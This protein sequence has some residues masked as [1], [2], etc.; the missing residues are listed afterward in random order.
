MSSRS[1]N[2]SSMRPKM[3]VSV[4][5]L[6]QHDYFIATF[7]F[8]H[9]R[10]IFLRITKPVKTIPSITS[11]IMG[12]LKNSHNSWTHTSH[13]VKKGESVD[14]IYYRWNTFFMSFFLSF[15]IH[16]RLFH[17]YHKIWPLTSPQQGGLLRVTQRSAVRT[18]QTCGRH[19]HYLS[20]FH[21]DN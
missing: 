12:E 6:Q 2:A 18:H 10:N 7:F 16:S 3:D 19:K 9:V 11:V 1:S 21:S 5:K 17:K 20:L 8:I 13:E 15:F 14:I 4:L